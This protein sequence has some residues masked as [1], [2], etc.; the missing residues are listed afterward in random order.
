VR[1]PGA[2][3]SGAQNA[4]LDALLARTLPGVDLTRPI[5]AE[6]LLPM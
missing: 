1:H 2:T 4:Q 5:T 3:I 6:Q